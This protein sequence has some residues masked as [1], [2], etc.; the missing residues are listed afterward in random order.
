MKILIL[1]VNGFIGHHL[2]SY[3]LNNTNWSVYGMDL[4]DDRVD[5]LKDYQNFYYTEGDITINKEW[6]KYNIKKC[7]VIIPLVAIATPSS[8]INDPLGVFELDFEANLPIIRSAVEYKK[9]LI[10]P[11]TSEVYGKSK[12]T[13][14]CPENSDLVLGPISKQRW[15][16]SCSKQLLDRIIYAYGEKNNLDY[17]L[18]RPFNWFGS[19][20]DKIDEPKEGGSRVITQFIGNISRGIDLS[21]VDGGLQ[22]RCFT[23]ID[24]G[25]SALMSILKNDKGITSKKI[26]NIGNPNNDFSIKELATLIINEAFSHTYWNK[27][28]KK[29]KINEVTSTSYYGKGYEDVQNRVPDITDLQ[30]DLN[31]Q[32]KVTMQEG[33]KKLLKFYSQNFENAKE[34]INK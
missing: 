33:L 15:I 8:Y 32:P 24:D 21:L 13:P 7:D 29:V 6:I 31:W 30:K 19:G 22:K 23:E 26:Y 3:I 1:G 9:R 27:L 5:H 12:E 28:A 16:Y 34:L 18:F 2:A 20:L 25:I 14:Y 17:T 4:S 11:S 10:F